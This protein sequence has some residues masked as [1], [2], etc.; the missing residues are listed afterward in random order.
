MLSKSQRQREDGG[1]TYIPPGK[2][3]MG[4]KPAPGL[5]LFEVGVDELPQHAAFVNGFY[6]DRY[7]ATVGQ[8]RQFIQATGHRP[9][10][11]WSSEYRQPQD[12]HPVIDLSWADAETYC[13]WAGKRLPTEQEWE[14]AARGTDGRIWPWG[15]QLERK[16]ANTLDAAMGW[17]SPVGSFTQDV[18]PY[19]VYDMAGNAMEWT[20]S[21]YKA[22]PGST[23]QRTAFGEQY[24]VLKGGSWRSPALPFSRAANRHAVAPKWDHPDHGVRCA[25]DVK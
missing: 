17:T 12:D 4:S 7:E 15:N 10:T 3:I 14:K 19:G 2:F 5:S 20:T 9:P 22:Y 1:M 11:M 23:L 13:R 25:K 24:R 16:H 8:Y 6:I 21:W 18:S